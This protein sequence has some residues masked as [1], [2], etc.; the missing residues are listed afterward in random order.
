MFFASFFTV[1]G[2]RTINPGIA[3]LSVSY[4][5]MI[6]QA[7]N[8]MVRQSCEIEANIVSVERIKEVQSQL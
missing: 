2:A 6:T 4:A 1:V 5:L 3:G 8:W 7:L